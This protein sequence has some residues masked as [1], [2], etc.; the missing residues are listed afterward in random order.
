[1]A[2]T[3]SCRTGLF[4]DVATAFEQFPKLGIQHAEVPPPEDGDYAGLAARARDAGVAIATLATSLRLDSDATAHELRPVIDG[5]RGIS[6]PRIFVSVG[7]PEGAGRGD[8]IQRLRETAEYA[9]ERDVTL[10]METHPPLGTN[11]DVAL[12]TL[13]EVDCLGL[14]SNFDTANIYYYNEGTDSVTELKKV[15]PFVG[16][17]HLKE[18][19]GGYHSDHFP[20]LGRGVVDFPAV[21]R[22]LGEHGF[23]GPYTLEVEGGA[24]RGADT[25]GRLEFLRECVD[26][27]RGIGV[28]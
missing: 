28:A 25:E 1:M 7:V 24:I 14:R 15:A 10:C 22:I 20:A 2:N 19:E 6:V 9:A 21:F 11:G 16:S 23:T 8:V 4:G 12:A 17:V 3:I 26:Y 5:A 27:L 18:T 13:T